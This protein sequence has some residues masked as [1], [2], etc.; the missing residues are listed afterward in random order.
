MKSI[1]VNSQQKSRNYKKEIN[2]SS[3][4]EKYN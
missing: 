4:V 3:R 2:R 1:N